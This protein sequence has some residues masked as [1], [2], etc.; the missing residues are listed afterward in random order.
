MVDRDG[1]YGASCAGAAVT[2]RHAY[3]SNHIG[4][5]GGHYT[6]VYWQRAISAHHMTRSTTVAHVRFAKYT[7]QGAMLH[8]FL[9]QCAVPCCGAVLTCIDILHVAGFP[10]SAVSLSS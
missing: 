5:E 4:T 10:T 8:L 9:L 2:L 3:F 1:A 6:Q 7:I